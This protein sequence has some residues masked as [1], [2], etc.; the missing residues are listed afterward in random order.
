MRVDLSFW[1]LYQLNRL[2]VPFVVDD[3]IGKF[4]GE[5]A[6]DL[7]MAE[8]YGTSG[9]HVKPLGTTA[10]M[11]FGSSAVSTGD[12]Y[13]SRFRKKGGEPILFQLHDL[14]GNGHYLEFADGLS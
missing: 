9:G 3:L 13:G 2:P 14:F 12:R 4:D 11:K 8:V 1:K 5:V 10:E 6:G 7:M